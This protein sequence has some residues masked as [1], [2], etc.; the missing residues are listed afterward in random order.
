MFDLYMVL[1]AFMKLRP[2]AV[3]DFVVNVNVNTFLTIS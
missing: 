1:V 2:V 3:L